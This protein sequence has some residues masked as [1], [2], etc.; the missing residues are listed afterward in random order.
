[1]TFYYVV[2]QTLQFTKTGVASAY[3][4]NTGLIEREH[5]IAYANRQNRINDDKKGRAKIFADI[6]LLDW[7]ILS[8]EEGK[9]LESSTKRL[10]L[11]D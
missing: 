2:I 5:P 10:V 8:E 11:Y 3:H 6:K 1:M 9:L 7:K 4:T